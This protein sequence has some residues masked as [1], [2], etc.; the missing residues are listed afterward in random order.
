MRMKI[1]HEAWGIEDEKEDE[2]MMPCVNMSGWHYN[3]ES[4]FGITACFV[5]SLYFFSLDFRIG[6]R[7][8]LAS[9]ILI[10]VNSAF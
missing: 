3:L 7:Q 1:R 4:V 8:D 9:E 10:F 5:R 2:I 6:V